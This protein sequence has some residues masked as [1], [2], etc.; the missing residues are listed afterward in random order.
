MEQDAVAAPIP[1]LGEQACD[2]GGAG[3]ELSVGVLVV[4]VAEGG[5]RGVALGRLAK[6]LVEEKGAHNPRKPA[7]IV[8]WI[9]EVPE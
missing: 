1:L 9:S 3:L 7:M 4:T 5:G 2:P 6:Q 8:R